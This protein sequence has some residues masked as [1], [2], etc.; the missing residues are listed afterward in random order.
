MPSPPRK[1]A[2][3][4]GNGRFK[5]RKLSALSAPSAD[6][7]ALRR[8]LEDPSIGGFG[9]V[10]VL[11]DASFAE[12]SAAIGRLFV[13]QSDEDMIVLYYS[14]HGLPD[15]RGNLYLATR[16]TDTTHPDGTAIHAAEIKRMMGTSRS[17]RQVLVLDCCYSGAFGAAKGQAQLPIGAETFFTQGFGQ[18]VL[19]ASRSVERAYEGEQEI[20]GVKTSLFTHFLVQG[21]E[22]GEAAREGNELVSV[23]D[24]YEYAFEGVTMHTNKMQPQMWVDEGR[25][26]LAIA[27]NP[28]PYQLP[29]RSGSHAHER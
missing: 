14:G 26:D 8:V 19:T 15:E 27:R 11:E 3:L 16:D 13:V 17:R 2:L 25:G 4:I 20:E 24:L 29:D 5:N 9:E 23:R 28:K 1:T 7:E 21:L 18:H 6:V 10:K 12:A 22:T